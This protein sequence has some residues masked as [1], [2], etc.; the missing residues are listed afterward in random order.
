[1]SRCAVSAP[2]SSA[3]CSRSR[4]ACSRTR[5][6]TAGG[7][8]KKARAQGDA[9]RAA[10]QRGRDEEA[11]RSGE[12]EEQERPEAASAPA[13]AVRAPAAPPPSTTAD[14]KQ[15]RYGRQ[16]LHVTG[17]VSSRYKK[18]RRAKAR[19]VSASADGRHAFEMP[20][21]PVVREVGIGETVT[22]AELAPQ[23]AVKSTEVIQAPINMGA[24][25]TI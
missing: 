6:I 8:R 2:T 7:K 9:R 17:D 22:V 10:E 12:R 1:M 16:E 13:P 23:M 15:T 3:T 11:R 21:A 5:L 14:D 19:P 4:R 24:I 20:T 18:K 25:A